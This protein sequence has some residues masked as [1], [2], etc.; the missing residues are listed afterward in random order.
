MGITSSNGGFHKRP[1]I[2]KAVGSKRDDATL[3]DIENFNSEENDENGRNEHKSETKNDV[4]SSDCSR[5]GKNTQCEKL[6]NSQIIHVES[7]D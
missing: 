4:Q 3:M 7:L 5:S 2:R 6:L 1:D